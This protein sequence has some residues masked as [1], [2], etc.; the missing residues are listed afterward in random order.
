[1]AQV[2]A[3][4]AV[5]TARV[6]EHTVGLTAAAAAE[7]HG[8]TGMAE[9]DG[10]VQSVLSGPVQPAVSHQQILAIFNQEKS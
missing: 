3:L 5:K 7:L 6:A 4:A 10:T 2:V 8:V 9:M 1:M